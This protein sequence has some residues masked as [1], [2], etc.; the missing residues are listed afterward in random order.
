MCVPTLFAIVSFADVD[1]P[2]NQSNDD[3]AGEENH[4]PDKIKHIVRIVVHVDARQT[5][6]EP[7]GLGQPWPFDR[8]VGNVPGEQHAWHQRCRHVCNI[9]IDPNHFMASP[10]PPDRHPSRFATPGHA[11][12]ATRLW[13]A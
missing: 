11:R 9:S 5:Q 2:H 1:E 7:D 3:Q 13:R 4:D 10:A 12:C 8:Q 6:R